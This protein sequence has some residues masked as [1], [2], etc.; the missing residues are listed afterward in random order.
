MGVDGV[1]ESTADGSQLQA[2]QG[3]KVRLEFIPRRD[4][5]KG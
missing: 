1:N 2:M 4:K 3:N 5:S